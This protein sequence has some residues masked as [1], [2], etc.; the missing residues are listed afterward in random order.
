M[1]PHPET[2]SLEDKQEALGAVP[3]PTPGPGP[4]PKAWPCPPPPHPA[5][6]PPDKAMV[7]KAIAEAR[8]HMVA[9]G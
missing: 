5:F 4:L 2:R 6:L 9:P 1:G 3:P 7:R 8:G